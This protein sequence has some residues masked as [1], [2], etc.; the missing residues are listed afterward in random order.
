MFMAR[1]IPNKNR[2]KNRN[3][4]ENKTMKTDDYEN[5]MFNC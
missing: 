5:K 2:N 4:T 1:F 3:R